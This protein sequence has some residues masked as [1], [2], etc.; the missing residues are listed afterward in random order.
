MQTTFLSLKNAIRIG[1]WNVRTLYEAGRTAL[2][3]REME[4]YGL[5][6][7]GLSEVRWT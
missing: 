5:E 2:V 6:I 1:A 7:L 4:K 3:A